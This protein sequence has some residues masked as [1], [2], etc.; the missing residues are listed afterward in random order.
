MG[1]EALGPVKALCLSV[2]DCQG[3]E[4][5]V[6]GLVSRGSGEGIRKGRRETYCNLGDYHRTCKHRKSRVAHR[7]SSSPFS[8]TGLPSVRAP[9]VSYSMFGDSKQGARGTLWV[10]PT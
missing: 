5:G 1:G 9:G 2:R 4:A 7:P 3:Q 6:G 10:S 8:S